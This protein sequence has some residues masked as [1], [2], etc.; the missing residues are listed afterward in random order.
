M[1][2][3]DRHDQLFF[4]DQM[5][6]QK[7]L[8]PDQ[9]GAKPTCGILHRVPV[10][11][12]LQHGIRPFDEPGQMAVNGVVV[13]VQNLE[14]PSDTGFFRG[15][16]GKVMLVL[17]LVMAMQVID[18]HAAQPADPAGKLGRVGA[19]VQ[20][21]L[22]FSLHQA[23]EFAEHHVPLQPKRDQPL[24]IAVRR[25]A[26][27]RVFGQQDAQGVGQAGAQLQAQLIHGVPFYDG[28]HRPMGSLWPKELMCKGD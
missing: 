1:A 17:D 24:K 26:V 27:A 20:Q 15:Q 4:V 19:A 6:V 11:T 10:I 23:H 25:P 18:E 9:T 3:D 13:A 28:C 8:Q 2:Q 16:N 14:A 7:P 21:S 12:A 5:A 22:G